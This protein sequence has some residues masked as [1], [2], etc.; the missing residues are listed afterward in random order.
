M[1]TTDR[2]EALSRWKPADWVP[3]AALLLVLFLVWRILLPFL[4]ALCWAF[5]LA[6][7]G[8]PVY[9]WLLRA[10]VRPGLAAFAILVL[11]ALIVIG[12]GALLA[13]ALAREAR[14]VV[15]SLA[16]GGFAL[17]QTGPAARAIEWLEAQYDLPAEAARLASSVAGLASAAVSGIVAGS[18]W[19]LSQAAVTLFVLFYFLR[20]GAAILR[21]ARPAIPLPD[22][23]VT[24]LWTRIA[25][26]LRVSL[27][28][29]VLMGTLQGALGGLIFAWLGLPAPVFWGFVMTLLSIFPVMGAFV[30]WAPVAAVLAMQGDWQRALSLTGWGVLVIHPVDNLLGPVLVSATLR[31]HSLLMFFSVIGGLAAFGSAGIVIG[32]VTVAV[33]AELLEMADRRD[34][35]P[36]R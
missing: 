20:D 18:V 16:D 32:P 33:V 17:P 34:A 12:P 35:I 15:K 29:K 11:V 2:R 21:K 6:V 10:Q 27:G 36:T 1:V 25:L 19:L 22:D 9:R 13:G 14:D 7:I 31:M 23:E 26:T 28:A 24:R 3:A 30:V 5:A 8:E 4:P